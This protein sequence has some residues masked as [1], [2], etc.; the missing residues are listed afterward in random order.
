MSLE[1][2]FGVSDMDVVCCKGIIDAFPII[3]GFLKISIAIVWHFVG[4]FIWSYQAE[5]DKRRKLGDLENL[6]NLNTLIYYDYST[7]T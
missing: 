2:G 5:R 3:D 4:S 1:S 7:L 6:L